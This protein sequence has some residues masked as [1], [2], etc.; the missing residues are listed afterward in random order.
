ME[1]WPQGSYLEG[2][3]EKLL[4]RLHAVF[5]SH[6]GHKHRPA[7]TFPSDT[8]KIQD[9]DLIGANTLDLNPMQI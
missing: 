8:F 1:V 5:A 9:I 2:Q 4:V 7:H 6:D 3:P